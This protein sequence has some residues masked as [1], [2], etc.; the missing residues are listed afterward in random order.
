MKDPAFLADA[1]KSELEINP[2]PGDEVQKLLKEVYATPP[3]IIAK[4]KA[5]AAGKSS[6]RHPEVRAK[7]AS[8]D[9]RPAQ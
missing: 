6:S 5:A 3:D 4:A 1:S 9:Q 8:K 2:V 7:R